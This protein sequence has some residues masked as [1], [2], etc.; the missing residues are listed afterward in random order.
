MNEMQQVSNKIINLT[1]TI[2]NNYPE[3][4]SFLDETPYH[5]DSNF[6]GEINLQDLNEHLNS[7]EEL[8]RHY[9]ETH[10]KKRLKQI[11]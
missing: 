9:I 1:S 10:H 4:Y 6:I 5:H 11:H 3:L 2:R 7:L 8:L